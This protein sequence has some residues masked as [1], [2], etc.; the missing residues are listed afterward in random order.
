MGFRHGPHRLAPI[1]RGVLIR[2]PMTIS[3]RRADNLA[4]FGVGIL[5]AGESAGEYVKAFR[6]HP[7][8]TVVGVYSRTPGSGARLLQLHGVAARE[9]SSDDELLDDDRVQIVV[10]ATPPDVRPAHVIRA[11]ESGRHIV[12]EKPVALSMEAV[13]QI[14]RAV[15]GSGVK[16]VT[17]F[18]LVSA[19][20][21]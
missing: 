11:A 17:S 21:R 5:G 9:Y 19:G 2:V 7:A 18:V 1:A 3:R 4:E 8:T 16:T 6:D 14:R 10:S 13:D 12:I 20:G 15:S